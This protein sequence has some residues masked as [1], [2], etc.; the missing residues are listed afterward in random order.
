MKILFLSLLTM[1]CLALSAA[2]QANNQN[3]ISG[4]VKDQNGAVIAGA[5]VFLLNTQTRME[6][7]TVSNTSGA[8]SF[9]NLSSGEYEVR[10]AAE[11]FATQKQSVR[12]NSGA[13]ENWKSFWR[14]GKVE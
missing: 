9:G 10:I 7:L 6:R 8:F 14:L 4:V 5:R 1:I 2:A 12:M 11:G 13:S 3:K